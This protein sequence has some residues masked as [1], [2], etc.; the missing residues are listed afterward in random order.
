[1]IKVEKGCRLAGSLSRSTKTR[2][3]RETGA[4]GAMLP[5]HTRRVGAGDKADGAR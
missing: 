4:A 5:G 3:V 2:F 1:M